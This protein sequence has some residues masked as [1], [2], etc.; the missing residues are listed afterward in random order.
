MKRK[1]VEMEEEALKLRKMQEDSEKQD[2]GI[3]PEKETTDARSV[4]IGNVDYGAS[5]EELQKHFE[6]AY[7]EFK[8]EESVAAAVALSESV[9][10]G[11]LIKV[12][13]K[14]TNVPFFQLAQQRGGYRGYHRGG[15]HHPPPPQPYYPPASYY[16]APRGSRG[17]Y[18][19]ARGASRYP[20][21]A[22]GYRGGRRGTSGHSSAGSLSGDESGSK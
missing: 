16:Y 11:R 5:P 7:V 14:R 2:D 13:P 12:L 9:L 22:S 1:L 8:D 3:S 20:R 15:Y 17:G 10:R 4:Y 21:G 6:F 18:A 19:S